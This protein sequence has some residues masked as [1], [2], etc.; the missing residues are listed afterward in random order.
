VVYFFQ[1]PPVE[2]HAHPTLETTVLDR[3]G[4][5]ERRRVAR[6]KRLQVTEADWL[7]TARDSRCA[8]PSKTR[9]P[10][11]A[12]VI[13]VTG[14]HVSLHLC[15]LS[16]LPHLNTQAYLVRNYKWII[17][18]ISAPL[19]CTIYILKIYIPAW[20]F[21]DIYRKHLVVSHVQLLTHEMCSPG[22][23]ECPVSDTGILRGYNLWTNGDNKKHDTILNNTNLYSISDVRK[24]T[25]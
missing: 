20:T 5:H 16:L 2:H 8:E 15:E 21:S 22:S 4:R 23:T 12:L 11:Y 25:M 10:S 3:G 7:R 1:R 24:A 18:Q 17:M 6:R 19:L 14:N 13:L 9:P